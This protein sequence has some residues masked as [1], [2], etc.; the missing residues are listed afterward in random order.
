LYQPIGKNM[1]SA[2]QIVLHD[3][4]SEKVYATGGQ[5]HVPIYVTG[6][7]KVGNAEIA[8]LDSDLGNVET[9]KMYV[10]ILV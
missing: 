7:I 6:I 8:V 3:S 9:H 4:E 1:L 5:I 2:L 10:S